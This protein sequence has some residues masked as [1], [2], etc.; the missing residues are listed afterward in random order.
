VITDRAKFL[1]LR[2]SAKITI[3]IR[4]AISTRGALAFK[5]RTH[6]LALSAAPL[7]SIEALLIVFAF[8]TRVTRVQSSGV[9]VGVFDLADAVPL[10]VDTAVLE[11]SAVIIEDNFQF[12]VGSL[13]TFAFKLLTHNL[14]TVPS[15]L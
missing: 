5:P 10:G 6:A 13:H 3:L 9:K 14:Q 15:H 7:Q 2:A 8:L 4:V 12:E 11:A 1:S